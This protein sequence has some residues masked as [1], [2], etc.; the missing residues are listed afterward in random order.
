MRY[1]PT[2]LSVSQNTISFDEVALNLLPFYVTNASEQV[3]VSCDPNNTGVLSKLLK[4]DG[5]RVYTETEDAFRSRTAAMN[6]PWNIIFPEKI[7]E[8]PLAGHFVST[9]VPLGHVKSTKRDDKEFVEIFKESPKW[10]KMR[11]IL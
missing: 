4:L 9:L 11:R 5:V 3:T 7:S 6:S 8:F 1:S 10:L 2:F